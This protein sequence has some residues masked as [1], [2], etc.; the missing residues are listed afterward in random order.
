MKAVTKLSVVVVGSGNVGFHL[1]RWLVEREVQLVQVFSR[2]E[3]K[4][5]QLAE[6]INTSF[7]TSLS[8]ITTEADIYILAVQDS[9][10]SS[11]AAQL[12]AI[13]PSDKIVVHTSGATP[14]TILQPFFP[15]SGV[16][17][18]LQTFSIDRQPDFE[19][20]PICIDAAE[21]DVRELLFLL[22]KRLSSVVYHLTD[23]QR[24]V[25]HVAAVFVNNFANHLFQIGADI[26]QKEQLPFDLVRPL[27]LETAAKV[28]Q[29]FP[30]TMQ[31]G[32]AIRRDTLTIERHLNY[33]E[34]FPNY[35]MLYQIL[36]ESIRA[37]R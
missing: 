37:E 22:G 7:T 26:L 25:A 20:I 24:A 12:A 11:V 17:Y 15:H 2:T 32:P 33:L 6:A 13:L 35:K 21:E 5:Q 8:E 9:A 36:T 31:T 30:E 34:Q 28:Q 14:M 29:H 23:E 1:G 3:A 18:P 10:I 16:F 27:I 4:A 19:S